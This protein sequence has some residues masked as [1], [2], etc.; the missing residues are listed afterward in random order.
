MYIHIYIYTWHDMH[1][2]W[3]LDV[4]RVS[5]NDHFPSNY[6]PCG[7][8]KLSCSPCSNTRGSSINCCSKGL[9]PS[10]SVGSQFVAYWSEW[11]NST[12]AAPLQFFDRKTTRPKNILGDSNRSLEQKN[13]TSLHLG[14]RVDRNLEKYRKD[15]KLTWNSVLVFCLRKIR[16]F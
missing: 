5:W 11:F 1:C 4:I 16:L 13:L 6:M 7:F 8:L 15:L 9:H 12:S 2:Y 10:L 14:R 3:S